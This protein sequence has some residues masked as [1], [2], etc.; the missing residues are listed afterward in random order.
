MVLSQYIINELRSTLSKPYFK[1]LISPQDIQA[2]M[3][4][5]QNETTIVQITTPIPKVATHPEYDI[6]LATAESG[7]AFHIVTGDHG[8]QSLGKFKN[9]QV[10]SPRVFSEFLQTK[11]VA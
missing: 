9:I 7:K 4:L 8:L 3:E 10:V 6:V 1:N 11:K 2:F 5:L